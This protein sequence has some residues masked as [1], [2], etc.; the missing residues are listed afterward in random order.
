MASPHVVSVP[1]GRR[2]P[3]GITM[4]AIAVVMTRENK[5]AWLTPGHL[6]MSIEIMTDSSTSNLVTVGSWG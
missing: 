1:T 3:N 2:L 6:S 4:R 5:K